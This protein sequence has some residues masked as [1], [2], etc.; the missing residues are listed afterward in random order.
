MREFYRRFFP[1]VTEYKK[2]FTFAFIAMILYALATS[3]TAYIIQPMLDEIFVKKDIGALYLF[4]IIIMGIFLIRGIGR[5]IQE[6]YMA[7]IGQNVVR[8]TRDT[9]LS[10]ILDLDLQ[11]FNDNRNGELISGI[12]NDITR[13]Q[14][15]VSNNLAMVIRESLT[16]LFLIGV[17]FYHSPK[18]ALI[19][20]VI[21]PLSIYPLS[22]LAKKMKKI[23]HTSQEK[24]SDLTAMLSE[25]FNNIEIIKAYTAINDEIDRFKENNR[26]YYK[27]SLKGVKTNALVSPVLEIISALAISGVILI[28]GLEVINGNLSVGSFFSFLTALFM[29]YTPFKALSGIY[30]RMQDA[31]AAGERIFDM[32][33]R[34][35]TIIDGTYNIT[36]IHNIEF[37][38]VS[39]SYLATSALNRVSFEAKKGETIALVGKSGAGKSS[40][41]NLILRFYEKTN[42]EIL[43]NNEHDIT[44][45]NTTSLRDRIAL[46][47]QRV[48][49]FNDTVAANVAYGHEIDNK[50]VLQAL[51]E[52]NALEF[53][54]SLE[55][56]IE[57]I[58]DEN[59]TNLSGGQRQ[60]ISIARALYK[61]PDVLI[62][63]EAT[64]ALDNKSERLIQETLAKVSK[65][66]ITFVIAH[67]L[68]TIEHSDKILVFNEGEIVCEGD[69][70]YLVEHCEVY[71]TLKFS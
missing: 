62:F 55:D 70:K 35:P 67:R 24:I 32:I 28:G 6:Y 64:S 65:D 57:T 30:N 15:A 19:G 13:I 56:G 61:N 45:Y 21:L 7:Y 11:F 59:G 66:K 12:T 42:G 58:L 9:L 44:Q 38:N 37:K 54:E 71:K 53:I 51:Q 27:V 4:P 48:L 17:I 60:R 5:F 43:F 41:V 31:V 29:L 39:L 1:Y 26:E 49:I 33:K 36:E 25:I 18:L 52:A 20:L 40:L 63:D 23:S 47:S 8:K 2:E 10:S 22:I 34:K 46:V 3:A 69:E 68:S 16:I 50:K 14:D